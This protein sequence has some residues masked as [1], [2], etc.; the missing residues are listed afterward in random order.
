M[1]LMQYNPLN[2]L[3]RIEDDLDKTLGEWGASHLLVNTTFVN[4]YEE[5]GKLVT[6]VAL[7]NFLKDEIA[8]TADHDALEVSAQHEEKEEKKSKRRYILRESTNHFFRRIALPEGTDSSQAEACLGNG[9]LKI[10]M[11]FAAKKPA[12][13]VTIK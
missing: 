9:L 2:D 8:I 5:D 1:Q 7:P 6:E 13:K 3:R 10:S 4:M 11:P 12:K